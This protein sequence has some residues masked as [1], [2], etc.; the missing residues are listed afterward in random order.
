VVFV[1][2][3]SK[4]LCFLGMAK[5]Q[6]IPKVLLQK[7]RPY[8]YYIHNNKGHKKKNNDRLWNICTSTPWITSLELA[9]CNLWQ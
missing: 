4:C 1:V 8:D 7:T 2:I 6:I 9:F 5:L 3:V